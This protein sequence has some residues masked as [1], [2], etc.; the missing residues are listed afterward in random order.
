M[1]AMT[2]LELVA[3]CTMVTSNIVC[4]LRDGYCAEQTLLPAM[5]Q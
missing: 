5:G 1:L 3:V 2:C 4:A